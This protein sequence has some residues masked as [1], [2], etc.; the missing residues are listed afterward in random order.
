MFYVLMKKCKQFNKTVIGKVEVG[1]FGGGLK[2]STIQCSIAHLEML[3]S[4]VDKN[5]WIHFPFLLHLFAF[6]FHYD[7]GN[8]IVSIFVEM[9][10]LSHIKD[11][12]QDQ[13]VEHNKYQN[14]IYLRNVHR[15]NSKLLLNV[16]VRNIFQFLLGLVLPLTL[17]FLHEK[18][19]K[20]E[21]WWI[22]Y[23]FL[24]FQGCKISQQISGVQK[25][26]KM[27]RIAWKN[28][29]SSSEEEFENP[30]CKKQFDK[31]NSD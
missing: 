11:L 7:F 26:S 10:Y 6:I 21:L 23:F 1:V 15:D 27:F 13:K 17:L 24:L 19:L 29:F 22:F 18:G 3:S 4:A 30:A 20:S 25:A 5:D 28:F 31:L 16:S 12:W 9:W 2:L 8:G 14:L